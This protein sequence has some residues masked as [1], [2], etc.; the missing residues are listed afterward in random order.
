M[1]KLD[2]CQ[3][4]LIDFFH[5]P[6]LP[7]LVEILRNGEEYNKNPQNKPNIKKCWKDLKNIALGYQDVLD[8]FNPDQINNFRQY[9]QANNRADVL[10]YFD[11][12]ITEVKRAKQ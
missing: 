11:R 2:Y 3:N 5:A 4:R 7:Y 8:N 1:P 6:D 9:L 10:F 12:F